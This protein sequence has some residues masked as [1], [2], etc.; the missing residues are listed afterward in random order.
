MNKIIPFALAFV[1]FSAAAFSGDRRI[2]FERGT[3]ESTRSVW[4]AN[5]DG[6]AAKRIA[7][8]SWPDISP[9]GT[10]LAFSTDG[11]LRTD[12]PP[13]PPRREIAVADITTGKV[14]I[15]KEIPSNNCCVPV[16]SPDGSKLAFQ[17]LV[18]DQWHLGWVKAD[19]SD[20]H[21]VKDVKRRTDNP[22]DDTI[23]MPA[24]AS[25]GKSIFCHDMHTIYQIDLEGNVLKK[26][27]LSELQNA[28]SLASDSRLSVSPNET[29]LLVSRPVK[30]TGKG[31]W[32]EQNGVFTF[33]LRT[34][35]MT[36]VSSEADSVSDACWLTNHEFLCK[37]QKEREERDGIYRMSIDGKN[38]KRLIKNGR[39]PSVSAP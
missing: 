22:S 2:A 32:V 27:N 10:R 23:W 19:G 30:H 18:D 13:R 21:L 3:R 7:Q 15:L 8:G 26:W 35:T 25:D 31:L 14:T 5:L 33:D 34:T 24:W 17:I 38:L 16:W 4:I 9:D 39:F 1:A 29:K 20:F 11:E 37:A 12:Q 36:R 6:T 28:G